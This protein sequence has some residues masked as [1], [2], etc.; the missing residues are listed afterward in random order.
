LLTHNP[1]ASIAFYPKYAAMHVVHRR[2]DKDSGATVVWLSD[3]T[4]PFVIVLIQAERV[5]MP[6]LPIAHLGVGCAAREEVDRLCDEA[7]RE[8]CLREGL[9]TRVSRSAI[10]RFSQTLTATRWK[11]HTD[12]KSD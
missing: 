6:L 1:E 10:G 11:S 3:R 5:S 2:I 12:R 4:R 9:P 7:R 8:G